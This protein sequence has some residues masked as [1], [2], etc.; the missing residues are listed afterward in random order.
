MTDD[1]TTEGTQ[2]EQQKSAEETKPDPN[3]VDIVALMNEKQKE[4]IEKAE[5]M[6]ALKNKERRLKERELKFRQKELEHRERERQKRIEAQERRKAEKLA[7]EEKERAEKQAESEKEKQEAV[8]ATDFE[9]Y[10]NLQKLEDNKYLHTIFTGNDKQYLKNLVK[11]CKDKKYPESPLLNE[12]LFLSVINRR[13]HIN[14]TYLQKINPTSKDIETLNSKI[15]KNQE[16][17]N[18]LTDTLEKYS[19]EKQKEIDLAQLHDDVLKEAESYVRQH[20][21]E[22]AFK[23]KVCGEIVQPNGFPH[24]AFKRGTDSEDNPI[25]FVWSE[26]MWLLVEQKLI[27]VAY[28]AFALH[29]SIRAIEWT[30]EDRNKEK[31]LKF[32]T[33]IDVAKE[34]EVLKGLRQ[35]WE[36]YEKMQQAGRITKLGVA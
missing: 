26:E 34:E 27:S 29:T 25:Y 19:E 6:D 22:F 23:C 24:W 11:E 8:S 21:G 15:L 2:E 12:F 18:K 4:N 13:L 10:Y 32:P 7:Q 3:R 31:A 20:I 36:T 28:M 30:F 1:K 5:K 16:Q 9:E 17:I 14:L 33:W 35:M